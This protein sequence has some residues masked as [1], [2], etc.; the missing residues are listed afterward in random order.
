MNQ[1]SILLVA[2]G[3]AVI[4]LLLAFNAM[5]R[6]WFSLRPSVSRA[7]ARL[8]R[9]LGLGYRDRRLLDRLARALDLEERTPLLVG[10]GCFEEAVRRLDPHEETLIRIE[11]LRQRIHLD[12][13]SPG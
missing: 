2:T 13:P 3:L 12:D 4:L 6:G 9:G 5:E 8:E 11:R 10:R 7:R 1:I